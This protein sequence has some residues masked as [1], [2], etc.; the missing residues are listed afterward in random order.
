MLCGGEADVERSEEARQAAAD[1]VREAEEA[2]ARIAMAE[3]RER[4]SMEH[5]EAECR[6]LQAYWSMTYQRRRRREAQIAE[7]KAREP[8]AEVR[9]LAVLACDRPRSLPADT[10]T[11]CRR[12][13]RKKLWPR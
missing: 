3:M 1:E 10:N 11:Y 13:G 5:A 9:R 6:P 7:A 2:E 12:S 8:T 4:R